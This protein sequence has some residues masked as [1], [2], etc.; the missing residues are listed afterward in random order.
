[1][2]GFYNYTERFHLHLVLEYGDLPLPPN[3]FKYFLSIFLPFFLKPGATVVVDFGWSDTVL[4]DVTKIIE[5]D[6]LELHLWV[7][8]VHSSISI[9]VEPDLSYPVSHS[10]PEIFGIIRIL[11]YQNFFQSGLAGKF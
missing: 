9:Q 4:Y 1:M 7:L 6:D 5:Q 2:V 8:C 10:S 3:C 11:K